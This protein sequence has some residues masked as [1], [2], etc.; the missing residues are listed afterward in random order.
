[1]QQRIAMK[2]GSSQKTWWGSW[3]QS[4][5]AGQHLHANDRLTNA[6]RSPGAARLAG[7]DARNCLARNQ[8]L[9]YWA[10][11][12]LARTMI[13]SD[14]MHGA[15]FV[16]NAVLWRNSCVERNALACIRDTERR[17]V[18]SALAVHGSNWLGAL[19]CPKKRVDK[20][21]TAI[22]S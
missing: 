22:N 5:V 9:P 3:T 7:K 10:Q 2:T 6:L 18:F 21:Q 1:M 12:T 20:E 15:M 4:R 17:A 19:S 16:L 8:S 14:V 13:R 11:G